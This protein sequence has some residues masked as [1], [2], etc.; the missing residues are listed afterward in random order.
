MFDNN[1]FNFSKEE[2]EILFWIKY[3]ALE[4]TIKDYRVDKI[5]SLIRSKESILKKETD[6]KSLKNS[7]LNEWRLKTA[8][9][10]QIE[11]ELDANQLETRLQQSKFSEG[12]LSAIITECLTF[13]QH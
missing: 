1:D 2:V 11:N 5:S 8:D 10:L 4:K 3:W 9:L 6:T 12:K 7:W 13:K